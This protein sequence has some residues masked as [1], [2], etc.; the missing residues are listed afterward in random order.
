MFYQYEIIV[1][2]DLPLLL[3]NL[4]SLAKTR[5]K[6]NTT[7]VKSVA[8]PVMKFLISNKIPYIL[9]RFWKLILAENSAADF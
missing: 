1:V 9:L 6:S 5:G 2:L 7:I 8:P 3:G 4:S